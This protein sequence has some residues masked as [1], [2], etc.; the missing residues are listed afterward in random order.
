MEAGCEREGV[1]LLL[2]GG[3]EEAV[4]VS[5]C[6]L[7]HFDGDADDECVFY[8]ADDPVGRCAGGDGSV[9]ERGREEWG[10]VFVVRG[11]GFEGLLS[12]WG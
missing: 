9:G 1:C 12:V 3:R 5:I 7:D 2:R 4:D 8:G 10:V 11:G 6:G